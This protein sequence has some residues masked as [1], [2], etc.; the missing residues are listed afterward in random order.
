MTFDL[1]HVKDPTKPVSLYRMTNRNNSPVSNTVKINQEEIQSTVSTEIFSWQK[2]WVVDASFTMSVGL[3]QYD[4]AGGIDIGVKRTKTV[5]SS[6]E[7]KNTVV[8][9]W[10][11]ETPITVPPYSEVKFNMTIQQGQISVP[12]TASMRKGNDVW[13]EMG[14]YEGVDFFDM[15]VN[16]DVR[17]LF[18]A[19]PTKNGTFR[20]L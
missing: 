10:S 17:D 12:F 18:F 11:F 15:D 6:S 16:I 2:T 4:S 19:G 5:G 7:T 13:E 20:V 3:P 9:K 1:D 14:T 8:H